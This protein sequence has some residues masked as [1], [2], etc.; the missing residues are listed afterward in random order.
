MLL[1]FNN[2]YYKYLKFCDTKGNGSDIG[3]KTFNE[4][5]I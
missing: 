3:F 5:E 1:D 2:K 4:G